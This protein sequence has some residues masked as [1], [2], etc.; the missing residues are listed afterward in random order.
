[1]GRMQ[2]T[3]AVLF[4]YFSLPIGL[5]LGAATVWLFVKY[6]LAGWLQI[7]ADIAICI[8][9]LMAFF[10]VIGL[11]AGIMWRRRGRTLRGV[12]FYL[13]EPV[14]VVRLDQRI[15]ARYRPLSELHTVQVHYMSEFVSMYED[16]SDRDRPPWLR[17]GFRAP[18]DRRSSWYC[19]MP[20]H[21]NAPDARHRQ[22][23]MLR[24]TLAEYPVQIDNI[25]TEWR[26][27]KR[28]GSAA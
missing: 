15:R 8:W 24:A 1:M 10:G 12:A 27:W 23:P 21:F 9:A 25:H 2:G 6:N 20:I 13:H 17:L 26:R 11:L 22:L 28:D 7:V 19:L 18:S 4:R 5:G 14:P 3:L 16:S